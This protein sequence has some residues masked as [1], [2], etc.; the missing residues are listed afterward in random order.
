VRSSFHLRAFTARCELHLFRSETVCRP[1]R[2]QSWVLSQ[3]D[4]RGQTLQDGGK[5]K[6][7]SY[8]SA[9]QGFLMS[10]IHQFVW[11]GKSRK[12]AVMWFVTPLRYHFA[13]PKRYSFI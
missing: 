13:S 8:L 10:S 11:Q 3:L 9:I 6:Q 1:R 5:R 2:S 12:E 7:T 4:L